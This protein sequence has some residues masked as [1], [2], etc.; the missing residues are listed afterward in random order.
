[1]MP[2][3]MS[4]SVL[5]RTTQEELSFQPRSPGS[6]GSTDSAL[7]RENYASRNHYRLGTS[8]AKLSLANQPPSRTQ[9]AAMATTTE[10]E[11]DTNMT[12]APQSF[13]DPNVYKY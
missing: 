7:R 4:S 11:T 10:E 12:E 9:R 5:P 1:M 6:M 3:V 2:A 13:G 8:Q